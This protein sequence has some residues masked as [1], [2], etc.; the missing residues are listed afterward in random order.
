[1]TQLE[2]ID[3]LHAWCLQARDDIR[4]QT[5]EARDRLNLPRRN[6]DRQVGNASERR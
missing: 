1:M 4:R 3:E 2:P 6:Y 5:N